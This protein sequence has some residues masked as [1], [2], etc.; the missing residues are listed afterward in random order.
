MMTATD[1]K[2]Q[3]PL[4]QEPDSIE[5]GEQTMN[6]ST[7]TPR[8]LGIDT[9]QSPVRVVVTTLDE[10]RSPAPCPTQEKSFDSLSRFA[11]YW[12]KAGWTYDDRF[13]VPEETNDP[14]GIRAWLLAQNAPLEAYSWTSYRAHLRAP[15]FGQ[16]ELSEP[17]LRAYALATYASYRSRSAAIAREVWAKV[18]EAQDLLKEIQH[19][20]HRLAAGLPNREY[21]WLAEP[22]F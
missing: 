21:Q 17:Y 19:A 4:F 18:F 10:D 22:P 20:V 3:L 14:L 5:I 6:W 13:A 15:E 1:L 9:S 7:P 16:L 2:G 11:A 8:I 12:T